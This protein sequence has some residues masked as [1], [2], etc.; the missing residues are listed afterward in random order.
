MKGNL[1]LKITNC[2]GYYLIE[3]V[4]K[5]AITYGNNVKKWKVNHLKLEYVEGSY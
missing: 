5:Q 3:K 4:P 1:K 2:F